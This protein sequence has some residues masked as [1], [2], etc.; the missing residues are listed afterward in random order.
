LNTVQLNSPTV[1]LTTSS[2]IKNVVS[3]I[4]DR[5]VFVKGYIPD[6]ADAVLIKS[7]L[8]IEVLY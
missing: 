5:P 1:I 3:K 7:L 2:S 6:K 8:S 4:S